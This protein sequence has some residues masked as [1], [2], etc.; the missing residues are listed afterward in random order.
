MVKLSQQLENSNYPSKI[1]EIQ[2][3]GLN[4]RDA[5][6]SNNIETSWPPKPSELCES[7]VN[8][9]AE[10]ESFLYTLLT[11]NTEILTE[12]NNRIRRLVHSFGQDVIY[13]VTG[14]RQ[15]P[16]KQILLPNAIKSL[17][18]NVELIQIFNRCGYGIAY[19]QIEEINTALCLQKM[20]LTPDNDIPLPENIQPH[21]NTT[22]PWDNIDRVEETLSGM[23][24]SHPVK[25]IA[26]QA[27]QFG[28]S[29]RLETNMMSL[30]SEVGAS[31]FRWQLHLICDVARLKSHLCLLLKKKKKHLF[32]V[33]AECLKSKQLLVQN[34]TFYFIIY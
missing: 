8:L 31:S 21:V 19:S 28:P 29:H 11:G 34:Q 15:K 26:V 32:Q 16:P 2:P 6:R 23:G 17:T 3:A 14:G 22:L 33:Y 7:A 5:V 24:T 25:G 1:K 27:R 4:I 20:A 30:F 18:N 12:Y 9:P 10:L 13:G